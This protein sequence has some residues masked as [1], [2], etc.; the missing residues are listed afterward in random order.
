MTDRVVQAAPGQEDFRH[1]EMGLGEIRQDFR[2]LLEMV[3]G[4]VHPARLQ[5]NVPEVIVGQRVSRV[6]VERFVV[7]GHG[8]RPAPLLQQGVAKVAESDGIVRLQ[9]MAL[10]KYWMAASIWPVFKYASPME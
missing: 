7:S 1:V 4:L 6:Q 5:K 8:L 9:L 3:H 10:W 2:R